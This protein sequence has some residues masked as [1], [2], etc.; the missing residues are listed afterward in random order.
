MRADEQLVIT[1]DN[2]S[3]PLVEILT[4]RGFITGKSGS[5]KSNSANVIAEEIM[6]LGRPLLIIDTDG[7][8]WGMKEQYSILHLGND[9][10]CDAKVTA[11]D[12][13][14]IV[15]LALHDQVPIILDVSGYL[16]EEDAAELVERVVTKLFQQEKSLKEPFL[17]VVEEVH[18]Y[19][20]EQGGLGDLGERLIQVAKRGRKHGLGFLGVSQ[21]PASVDKDFIT[22]CDWIV[23]HRLTWK[24]DTEVVRSILGSDAATTVEHLDTGEALLMTDW[25]ETVRQIMFRKK[26]TYDAGATPGLGEFDP[27]ELV[28]IQAD[29]M[30]RFDNWGD[31]DPID[32]AEGGER[33]GTEVRTEPDEPAEP[34]E[35]T[36]TAADQPAAADATSGDDAVLEADGDPLAAEPAAGASLA[37]DEAAVMSDAGEVHETT[38]VHPAEHNRGQREGETPTDLLVEF[39]QLV[40]FLTRWTGRLVTRGSRAAVAVPRRAMA[41]LVPG[42]DPGDDA[43][44]ANPFVELGHVTHLFASR[45]GGALGRAGL[46]VA[47]AAARTLTRLIPGVVVDRDD[48]VLI[49]WFG[50]IALLVALL[51][52]VLV[53]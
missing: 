33:I 12:A 6:D 1:K 31:V 22:Q 9:D 13:D 7:E 42:P 34:E 49:G 8:Y 36:E 24:N 37:G 3:L 17:L 2:V 25:D 16:R 11:E 47:D 40:L 28:P 5:G 52:F 10:V 48:A 35:A 15:D 50:A 45:V 53:G 29:V 32:L 23:W 4:G 21:R 26:A 14:T 46:G 39:G 51:T 27:P 19:I 18:E 30:D 38:P 43:A 41:A 44:P 20:P